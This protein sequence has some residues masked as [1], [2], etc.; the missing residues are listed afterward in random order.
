MLELYNIIFYQPLFNFLI[1]LYNVVPGNDI[2]LAIIILTLVIRLLLFPLYYQSIRSQRALQEIQPKIDELRKR[3]KDKK[4]ELAKE[5]M[6]LYKKEKVNPFS[7]CLPLIIQ[8][9]FLIAVYQV[10]R[11]GLNSESLD[12]LYPFI[13][14]P[15][16]INSISLGL[17]D[18]AVPSVVLA[19]LAGAAQFWQAKMMVTTKPPLIKGKEITGSG[20]EKML[21][22]M[23]KQMV[24]FMPIITIV[25]GVSLPAGLTLYWFITTLLMAVQQLWMFKRR[26]KQQAEQDNQPEQ[27]V[28]VSQPEQITEGA[29][30]EQDNQ[31]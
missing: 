4:E 8:L 13:H 1:W 3:L 18:L 30:P 31:K 7:S 24:Y 14:N 5:M 21:A 25:I 10:F 16:H 20:D 15:E 6:I 11:H 9:P 19:F 27:I 28:E 17:I 26:K 22:N 12:L 29:Q 2:G 23:N